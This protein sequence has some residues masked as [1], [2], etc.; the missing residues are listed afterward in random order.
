VWFFLPRGFFGLCFKWTQK[1]FF[2]VPVSGDWPRRMHSRVCV[3]VEDNKHF[4]RRTG[5]A[6]HFD[7]N[8]GTLAAKALGR[9]GMRG[10]R[11]A[12]PVQGDALVQQP[13]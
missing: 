11:R 4:G 9:R 12:L 2:L 1:S 3:T 8:A 13:S 10:R 5:A 6:V 7:L